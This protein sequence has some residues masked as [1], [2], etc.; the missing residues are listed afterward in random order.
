MAT[1]AF[2]IEHLIRAQLG[3]RRAV[4]ASR[5]CHI[6]GTVTGPARSAAQRGESLLP[7]KGGRDP[8]AS[9]IGS[10][11]GSWSGR[12]ESVLGSLRPAC[13]SEYDA[14]S[15][16]QRESCQSSYPTVG[17]HEVITVKMLSLAGG[18]DFLSSSAFSCVGRG[19]GDRARADTDTH[20]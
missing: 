5:P 9:V 20:Q 1:L 18:D 14:R 6:D 10:R 15:E 4:R 3:T 13:D 2:R 7:R 8:S 19:W 16:H 17:A 11:L 12:G